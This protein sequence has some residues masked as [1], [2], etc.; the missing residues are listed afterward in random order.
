MLTPLS[1]AFSHLSFPFPFPLFSSCYRTV[2]DFYSPA[3]FTRHATSYHLLLTFITLLG[4]IGKLLG[5]K[6]KE[7]DDSE[8]KPYLEQAARD[9][10]RAEQEKSEYDVRIVPSVSS[11]PQP[12][13]LVESFL[14]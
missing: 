12:P 9:K 14:G 3:L 2:T 8:K 13:T 7:L 10:A 11:I 6:W 1:P 5:A 4:E